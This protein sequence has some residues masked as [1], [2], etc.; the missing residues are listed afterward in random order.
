[1]QKLSFVAATLALAVI[2][3]CGVSPV[4]S[5]N[6]NRSLANN[7]FRADG[8]SKNEVVV[9]F[10]QQPSGLRYTVKKTI[11]GINASVLA[12]PSGMSPE[13]VIAD[14]K[15]K[16]S[17]RYAQTNSRVTLDAEYNDPRLKDQYSL[18][19]TNAIKA[20]D[21]TKGDRNTTIAV[22]D[23]GIDPTH[24]DLKDK[25]VA[26]WNVFT[27]TD[28]VH[29]GAGHGTHTAGIAAAAVGNGEGGAGVAPDCG[30]MIVQVL[31]ERG[32]GSEQSIADGIVWAADHGAKVMTMSLGLYKHSKVVEDALQYALDK[33]VVCVASAG[34]N[35][36]QNDAQT[37]PHLPSTYPGVIEVAATDAQ[38]K[39]AS[40]SNWGNT[41]TVAAP[42]VN[43]LSTVPTYPTSDAS[44]TTYATMSGTSMA[45][46]FAAG[47][48]ALI[49]SRHP[50]WKRDQ[51][52][53]A[54]EASTVDLGDKGFD[55][56]FGNGR[57]DALSAVQK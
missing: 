19:L 30:L 22:I 15:A 43:I 57:V 3:G 14:V 29:D 40:F 54:L 25:V 26:S 39:K 21:V 28:K 17:V 24:P 37:A 47:V 46:P 32:S 33:D 44:S 34:N 52:K 27:K 51:V 49:R 45:S 23:T 10:N 20:W 12:V 50:E 2:A 1:M 38:D 4:V 53:K 42:G 9:S 56:Y 6:A 18:N 13:Q 41:V 35:N 55:K 16:Y 48:A 8:V 36:A 7:E 31:D 5:T 11:R